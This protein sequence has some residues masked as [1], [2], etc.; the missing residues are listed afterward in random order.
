MVECQKIEG[1]DILVCQSVKT[2]FSN[3]SRLAVRILSIPASSSQSEGLFSICGNSDLYHR[4]L[5]S[6]H[7]L[8]SWSSSTIIDSGYYRLPK[9]LVDFI[10]II[11]W[12]CICVQS[13][14]KM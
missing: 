4:D 14:S 1:A 6:S 5:K 8:R 2:Q 7:I 13:I 12:H 3:L 11:L 10:L 9:S